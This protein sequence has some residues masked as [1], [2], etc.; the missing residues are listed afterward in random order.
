[1]PKEADFASTV[2]TVHTLK[3]HLSGDVPLGL[4]SLGSTL[5]VP[6]ISTRESSTLNNMLGSQHYYLFK[7]SA[8]KTGFL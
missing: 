2:C 5:V 1:M 8:Y 6:G 3:V 4:D 7:L